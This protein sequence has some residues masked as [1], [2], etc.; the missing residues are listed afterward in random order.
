VSEASIARSG[1]IMNAFGTGRL[2][3]VVERESAVADWISHSVSTPTYP[4]Q[5]VK[6][7]TLG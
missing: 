6:R 7:R 5:L 3:V 4:I 2:S 1:T